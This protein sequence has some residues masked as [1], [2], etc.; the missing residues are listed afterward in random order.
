MNACTL[1]RTGTPEPLCDNKKW[2]TCSLIKMTSSGGRWRLKS[3]ASLFCLTVCSGADQRKHQRSAS[4]AFARWPVASPRK[5]LK[6]WKVF[7][8]MKPSCYKSFL[9]FMCLGKCTIIRMFLPHRCL[10]I[11]KHQDGLLPIKSNTTP[12]NGNSVKVDLIENASKWRN[13]V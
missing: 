7:H 6:T 12:M 10:P 13:F 4:L 1:A 3:P 2:E 9:V 11:N 8:L 5:G